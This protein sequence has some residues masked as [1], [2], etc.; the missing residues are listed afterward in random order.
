MQNYGIQH[1]FPPLNIQFN[2]HTHTKS[3]LNSPFI[4][5]FQPQTPIS[6]QDDRPKSLVSQL[7][8]DQHQTSLAAR[9]TRCI[10]FYFSQAL[11]MLKRFESMH[12][13]I[14]TCYFTDRCE[15]QLPVLLFGQMSDSSRT[16]ALLLWLVQ[17]PG[18]CTPEHVYFRAKCSYVLSSSE[19]ACRTNR[20]KS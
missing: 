2:Q 8:K 11:S 6:E 10:P 1:F 14:S 12:M 17:I 20:K 5:T 19:K 16:E 7:G 18:F 9:S 3:S 4:L 15:L 13:G